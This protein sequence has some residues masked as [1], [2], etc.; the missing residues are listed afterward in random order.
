ML[1]FLLYFEMLNIVGLC[2]PPVFFLFSPNQFQILFK[3]HEWE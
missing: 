3:L 2:L 1:A